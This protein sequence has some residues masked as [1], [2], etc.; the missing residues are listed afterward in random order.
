MAD[1]VELPEGLAL[2]DDFDL[3]SLDD[4]LQQFPESIDHG[5]LDAEFDLMGS[6]CGHT[7]PCSQTSVGPSAVPGQHCIHM[8][9][10]KGA[11][12]ASGL[13]TAPLAS[14]DSH[15]STG[16][17]S[18]P[19][20]SAVASLSRHQVDRPTSS[21][22]SNP[23]EDSP[24]SSSD[25]DGCHKRWRKVEG[26]AASLDEQED[27]GACSPGQMHNEVNLP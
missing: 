3:P 9:A 23:C 16:H 11:L 1:V 15:C 17:G 19:A 25:R 10:G 2:L 18:Q 13:S 20:D 14:F 5:V 26:D 12:M 7:S 8:P 6:C 22:D 27:G 4:L 24:E 21:N